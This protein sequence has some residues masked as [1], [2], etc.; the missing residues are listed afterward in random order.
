MF[1]NLNQFI[2]FNLKRSEFERVS[3][4]SNSDIGTNIDARTPVQK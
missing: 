4:Q 1:I 3:H 2:I